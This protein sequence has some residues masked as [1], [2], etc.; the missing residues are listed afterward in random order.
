M[1]DRV[2]SKLRPFEAVLDHVEPGADL[3]MPNANGEPAKL[4]DVLE[5][6]ADKL[7]GVRVHQMH[8]LRE[9]R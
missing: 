9:R 4:I 7:Q 8:A 3:I 2:E 5:E 1:S 6:H